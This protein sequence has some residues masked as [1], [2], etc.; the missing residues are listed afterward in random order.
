LFFYCVGHQCQRRRRRKW[1]KRKKRIPVD[2]NAISRS[3]CL[4]VTTFIEE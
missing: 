4:I 1:K 2:E 3:V